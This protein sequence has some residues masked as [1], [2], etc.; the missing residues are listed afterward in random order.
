MAQTVSSLI[1]KAQIQGSMAATGTAVQNAIRIGKLNSVSLSSSDV[2]ILYALK[3][4]AKHADNQATWTATTG[5]ITSTG[6]GTALECTEAYSDTEDAEGNDIAAHVTIVAIYY[7]TDADN[8]G[9]VTIANSATMGIVT[10]GSGGSKSRSALFVPRSAASGQT[11][12]IDFSAV[13]DDVTMVV[14]ANSS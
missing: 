9:D 12:T 6:S 13:D 11:V 3:L 14:M 8:T 5:D 1:L 7:E 2:D 10:L 4:T